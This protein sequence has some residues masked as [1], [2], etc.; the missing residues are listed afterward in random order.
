MSP[1]LARLIYLCGIAGLFYLDR[2]NDSK[3]SKA[4][5]LPVLYLWIIG[6]RPISDWLGMAP[7]A[8]VDVQMDGSPV[9]RAFFLVLLI[10]G[11]CVLF[12]RGQ[13][14]LKVLNANW[15]ILAFY[16]FCLVSVIWSDYTAV[17]FK[18]WSKAIADVAMV[19][20]IV[21]DGQPIAALRRVFSRVGFLL[22]PL[23]L[24]YIKYFP[25]LGRQYDPWTGSQFN[26][27]VT[28]NKNMLGS[29]TYLLLLGVGWKLIALLQT[30]KSAPDRKR[31]LIAQ[32]V[33][34]AMGIYLLSITNSSTSSMC[35]AIGITLLLFTSLS[36]V[37]RHPTAVHAFVCT[38]LLGFIGAIALSG[39]GGVAHALGRD[40]TFSGRTD[41]W[42]DVIP[43][44]KNPLVG[45]GF[46]SFW[47]SPYVHQKLAILMPGLPLNEAHNG[48][49]EIYLE[50]GFVGLA[51]LL[52]VLFNGYR[53]SV[54]AFSRDPALASL[55]I[56]Y[57]LTIM[58]YCLT[59]AG[60]RM[61]GAIWI[62]LLLSVLGASVIASEA[63]LSETKL[64]NS[65]LG[66]NEKPRFKTPLRP[67]LPR[68]GYNWKPVR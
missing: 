11:L 16:G 49:I 66:R 9:D 7:P 46:E 39:S 40:S 30:D 28:L 34:L 37:K 42:A 41:I 56:A 19:V 64:V 1:S 61:V 44:A 36:Y 59:E 18:R 52:L 35:F 12:H 33:L 27:G 38:L 45:A 6:S 68:T 5:W 26:T 67:A 20:I 62:F 2:D 60:F 54:Q 22:I 14:T 57:I 31:H 63:S 55:F 17:S 24:L 48:Y 51:L 3:T 32:G 53:R 25:E 23:S 47:L 10:A 21:T 43:L 13:R 4:L 29:I 15:P 58:I 65:P 8:D 50:L